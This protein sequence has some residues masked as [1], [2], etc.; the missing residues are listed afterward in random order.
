MTFR[1][2]RGVR[3]LAVA[4]TALMVLGSAV[5]RAETLADTLIAAYRNSNLLEQNRAVLRAADEDVAQAVAALRPVV[6]FVAETGWAATEGRT[7][8]FFNRV[9]AVDNRGIEDSLNLTAQF[10]IFDFGRGALG[11][12]IAKES[13]LATR[14]ALVNVEQQ[15]LLSA[16]SAYVRVRLNIEIVGLR[17]SNMRLISE[18]LQAAQDRFDLGE[19]T[20]TDVAIAE[21]ALAQ[22]RSQLIRAQ[23]D[24]MTARE[25]FRLAVGRYPGNLAPMPSRPKTASSLD[26]ARGVAER[27]HPTIRQAQRQVSVAELQVA[28][29]QAQTRPNLTARAG[30]GRAVD[31]EGQLTTRSLSL[32]LSQTIYSGGNLSSLYRQAMAGR[33]QARSALLQQVMVVG[34]A[35]GASWADLTA[36]G[37]GIESAM[38]QIEAAQTAFDGVREEAALGARTTLD[39]LDAEQQLLEARVTRVVAE[40]ERDLAIYQL[41]SSMGLLTVEHLGLGIPTY[42]PAAYYNAVKGAPL[43][44]PQSK[45]L[46]RIMKTVGPDAGN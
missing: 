32:N 35:V 9:T 10:I 36:A 12:E 14:E 38:L 44:S 46:D 7:L 11:L 21:A 20:R 4:A 16:V 34:Q 1:K 6:Q 13:V 28:L 33:D 15:V 2:F 41:L 30:L 40:A 22:A 19:I 43:T 39:V 37:A 3:V 31:D 17:E 23:G 29:A 5:A 27:T 42:D 18:Q 26:E 45:A 24:L 8:D 25:D